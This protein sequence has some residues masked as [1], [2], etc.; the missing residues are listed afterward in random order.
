MTKPDFPQW[1]RL[2]NALERLAADCSATGGFVLDAW[3]NLWCAGNDLYH[4]SESGVVM[5]L[6]HK[7]LSDLPVA[8]TRGG[9]IDLASDATY[10][11][12]F[13]GIYVLVLRFAGPFD[14]AT[15]RAATLTALPTIEALTLLLPPPG[16]P[17]PNGAAGFGVA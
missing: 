5:D 1:Q 13:A 8:L 11:R 10:F 9:R 12:S 6:T 17:D 4:G 7:E 16:G 14:L 2:A 15:V 3:A